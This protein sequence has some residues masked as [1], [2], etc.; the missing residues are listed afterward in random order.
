MTKTTKKVTKTT[1]TATKKPKTQHAAAPKP[2]APAHKR[3][4]KTD[5]PGKKK[6]RQT[7]IIIR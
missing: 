7:I 1:K 2:T 3:P 5:K 6:N 4:V